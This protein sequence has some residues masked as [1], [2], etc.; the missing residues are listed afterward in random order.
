[1]A[2]YIVS[3]SLGETAE[4]VVRAALSQFTANKLEIKRFPNVRT[5]GDVERIFDQMTSERSILIH[6][7][8]IHDLRDLLE[9]QALHMG[10][11]TID[12]LNPVIRELEVILEQPANQQPGQIRRMDEQYF[13]KMDCIRFANTHDDGRDPNG[14]K[15]ADL[16]LIGVSRT[17]KTPLA[18]YLATKSL[19]VANIP[20][21]P[22]IQPAQ[23]LFRVSPRSI[24]G[25]TISPQVLR[26]IRMERS[27]HMGLDVKGTYC[28][29][30]RITKELDFAR[31]WMEKIGCPIIDVSNR[32]VEETANEIL[33]LYENMQENHDL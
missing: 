21:V 16:V 6:T 14:M 3:D 15:Q 13:H 12:L 28:S 33:Q 10:M 5:V 2:I 22:E 4:H 29:L 30:E 23:E 25:I 24:I 11:K 20:L 1:M 7:I 26:E 8:V 19:K 17:S 18:M 31:S 32:S 9:R 27:K